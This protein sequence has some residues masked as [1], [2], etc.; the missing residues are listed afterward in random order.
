MSFADNIINS[1]TAVPTAT[2]AP[3]PAPATTAAAA[4]GATTDA[5]YPVRVSNTTG[6]AT[7]SYQVLNTVK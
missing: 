7:A 4:T 2:A 5:A 3:A 6:T 1:I